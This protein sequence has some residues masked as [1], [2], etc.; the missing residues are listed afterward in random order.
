[1]ANELSDPFGFG[2]VFQIKINS[3]QNNKFVFKQCMLVIYDVKIWS[4]Q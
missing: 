1:M 4:T 2:G 3:E